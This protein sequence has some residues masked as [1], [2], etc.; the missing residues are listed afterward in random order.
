MSKES[1]VA[2]H[3][4][5]Y[6]LSDPRDRDFQVLCD[7]QHTDQ[8]DRCDAMAEVLLDVKNALAMM[9][10][11]NI[12]ADAKE[13]L[14]FI[15]DKAISNIQAWKA[16]L[17]RSLNQDQ[18][19]L[20]V[21]DE[22]DES[23]V[24]LIEDWAMKFLPCKYRETQQD[25]YGKRGLSWH[26]TVATRKIVAT[27]ELQMMTFVHVFQ[28]CSQDSNAVL[29]IMEDIIGKLKAIMPTL[30]S[31]IYRQ[32]NAGC[33][34]SGAT[35]IG[36][37]KASQF[38]GVTVKRLDF[39][40]P[41]AGKGACDRKAATIKARMRIHLNEGN[42]IENAAQMVEAMRSSGGVSSLHVTLCEMANPRTSAIVKFDGVSGV[43]NVE[44]GEDCITTWKAY[45]IGPGKTF[46]L[47]K[48][49][50]G[51]NETSIPRLT[52][53]VEDVVVDKFTS[54]QS[55]STKPETISSSDESPNDTASS[56]L[57][58]CPEE[59]CVKSYQRF[60]ALQH[61]L[62]C[63]KHERKLERETLLDKAVHGYAARLEKQT[64]SVPKLQQ[65]AESRRAPNR[66]LL[67]MG[68]ALKSSQSSRARFTDKQ[69]NYLLSKFLIGE[70]TGQKLNAS[71]VARSMMSARD[72]NGDR[73]FISNE[74]LTAQ[75]IASYFSRL[76]SKR[77]LQSSYS[78][79]SESDDEIAEAEMVF[80]DLR[81]K[82]LE[83]V[84]PAHPISFE[85][86]NRDFK[87]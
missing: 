2:D 17:L 55:R 41:Q 67:P 69:K 1:C 33:Y 22:L 68:W 9:T 44:Y 16:H 13:E 27:Q 50:R 28:S 78:S 70:Q 8:C 46:K 34:R 3:C 18:A 6:S 74:F 66:S 52:K 81:G 37:S 10:D 20:D 29:A 14:S 35:I 7:H 56:H 76:A 87:I 83:N 30:K 4:Q 64:A 85:H 38:H 63:G 24:L 59:G 23:S 72:E 49:T 65:C 42:E 51:N 48:L 31:V 53:C 43:L 57:F 39:S 58:F 84:Q 12:G 86:Y 15:A 45:G 32:D 77:A 26:V 75:Q 25:W 40:D 61:H 62:D 80:S 79:Q 5:Q 19:R 36:A 71:S 54:L 11:E 82:V 73:L 47:S 60:A 21:I